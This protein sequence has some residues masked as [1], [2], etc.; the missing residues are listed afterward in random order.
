MSAIRGNAENIFSLRVLPSL[1]QFGHPGRRCGHP[2]D[3]PQSHLSPNRGHSQP[4]EL[5][6]AQE[7]E[8][9]DPFQVPMHRYS[10]RVFDNR[11]N[12]KRAMAAGA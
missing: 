9:I 10:G 4:L 3:N 7:P 6:Y 8:F 11:F 5:R 1:T 12:T 2:P